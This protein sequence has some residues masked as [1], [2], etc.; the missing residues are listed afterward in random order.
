MSP[1]SFGDQPEYGHREFVPADYPTIPRLGRC[2]P[3]RQ[4]PVRLKSSG[5]MILGVVGALFVLAVCSGFLAMP[6]FG[7]SGMFE[8]DCLRL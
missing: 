4:L 5:L 1:S 2:T 3:G 6:L 8:L 7:I